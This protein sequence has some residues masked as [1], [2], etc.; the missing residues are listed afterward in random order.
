MT[1]LQQS[2]ALQRGSTS[3]VARTSRPAGSDANPAGYQHDIN[4]S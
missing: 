2:T 3:L 4:L 1:A